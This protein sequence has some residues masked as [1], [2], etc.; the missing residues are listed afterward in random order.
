MRTAEGACA[1]LRNRRA[2]RA[3]RVAFGSSLSR[4]PVA[5]AGRSQRSAQ[6]KV[7]FVVFFIKGPAWRA[8]RP[9]L[10]VERL[11]QGHL[12]YLRKHVESGE[13]A[14]SGPLVDDGP[15][16]GIIVLGTESEQAARRIVNDDPMVQSKQ[17]GVETH[18]A[19]FPD[20]SPLRALYP[21]KTRR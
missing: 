19:M 11:L 3:H 2:I 13:Y 4:G 1:P 16:R 15:I 9:K 21:V 6:S 20:L 7:V 18:P 10:E 12:A 14:L 5:G 8:P 17:F